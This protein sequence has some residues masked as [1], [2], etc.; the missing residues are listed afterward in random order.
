MIISA[1]VEWLLK[2]RV[3]FAQEAVENASYLLSDLE[4]ELEE[5]L[6]GFVN[7]PPGV[8]QSMF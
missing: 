3:D 5:L 2:R 7:H 6:E 1:G 4:F 8:H